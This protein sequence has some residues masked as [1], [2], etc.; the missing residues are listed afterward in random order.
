[1]KETRRRQ[2]H[3]LLIREE[4]EAIGLIILGSYSKKDLCNGGYHRLSSTQ[5]TGEGQR[6]AAQHL[7][8]SEPKLLFAVRCAIGSLKPA[9]IC[10]LM[11]E[12]SPESDCVPAEADRSAGTSPARL[13]SDCKPQW[14]ILCFFEAYRWPEL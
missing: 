4:I 10:V 2:T 3:N 12:T 8:L 11:T 1:V 5:R 9:G 13:N 14:R 7:A 6:V